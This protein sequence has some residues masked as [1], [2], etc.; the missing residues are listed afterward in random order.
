MPVGGLV[1]DYYIDDGGVAHN[2]YYQYQSTRPQHYAGG[3]A[4]YF[5]GVH[6][7]KFGGGWRK[8]PVQTQQTWPASHMVATWDSYPNMFV[9]VARDYAVEHRRAVHQRLSSPTRSRSI[10]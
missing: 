7:L 3:D 4:S 8:T 10:A 9:Q 1:T 5:A 2:T 6:E